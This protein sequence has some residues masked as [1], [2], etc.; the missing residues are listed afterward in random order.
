[1]ITL[2]VFEPRLFRCGVCE[3]VRAAG[4]A[5]VDP[6]LQAEVVRAAGG[7]DVDPTLQAEVAESKHRLP[8]DGS[9]PWMDCKIHFFY[10]AFSHGLDFFLPK[11]CRKVYSLRLPN[12]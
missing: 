9:R 1:M 2:E 8:D 4:G 11:C 12:Y 5:D 6:T 7:V 3:V 10:S